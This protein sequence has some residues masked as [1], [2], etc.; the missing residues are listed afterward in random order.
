MNDSPSFYDPAT[1][2]IF[3]SN[4]L[5]AFEHLYRFAMRRS[6]TTAL[7]DQQFDW[8]ARLSKTSPAAALGLRATI[9]GDAL[10]VAN[11]LAVSDAPD[12]LA[13]EYLSFV[14]GHGEHDFAI[15]V[16]GNHHRS[17][18]AVMRPTM[19]SLANDPV[20]LATLEQATPSND[21]VLDVARARADHGVGTTDAGD[22]VLVLRARQPDRR[23]PGVVGGRSLDERLA[24]DVGW[25]SGPCIDATFGA[26]DADGAAAALVAFQTW[27]SVAPVESTTTVTPIDGNQIAIQACD[28]GAVLTAALP[29]KVPVVFGGSGCRAR[30]RAIRRQRR[31]EHQGRLRHASSARARARGTVFS[32]P[33]DDAPVLAVD[34]QPA[35]V[36]ANI[37][38]AAT[39]VPAGG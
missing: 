27:A 21:A 16:R 33:S 29:V 25:Y 18:Q 5:K 8:S 26:A 13:P 24:D 11:A 28:P 38:L 3:V 15:A 32:S 37:D 4:D 10:A 6:L 35:Y 30:S 17:V 19:A 34:W 1:K 22:D 39:C 2:T 36:A 14:Q 23:W 9:D 7:L 20:S 12:Q 31:S